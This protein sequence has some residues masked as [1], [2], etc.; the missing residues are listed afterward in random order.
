MLLIVNSN[1]ALQKIYFIDAFKKNKV[2]RVSKVL[3]MAGGKGINTARA[4]KCL[5]TDDYILMTYAPKDFGQMLKKDLGEN[6]I[7][8]VIETGRSLRTC[9]TIIDGDSVTEITEPNV[10]IVREAKTDF[11]NQYENLI[12]QAKMLLI[13]GTVIS[14]EDEDFYYQLIKI[15]NM[16]KIPVMLDF[17]GKEILRTLGAKIDFFKVNSDEFKELGKILNVKKASETAY[18]LQYRYKVKNIIVT[19]K[20]KEIT[21][22]AED[23]NKFIVPIPEVDTLNTTGCGD[24]FSAGF[25]YEYLSCSDIVRSVKRGVAVSAAS[26]VTMEMS[27]FDKTYADKLFSEII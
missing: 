13:S 20:D 14:G 4:F 22:F 15:A 23:D 2:N 7:S 6:H 24:A 26:A 8:T 10:A 1:P 16:F 18:C 17:A 21:V 3:T 19:D 27:V 25:I 5:E 11:R 12:P 9:T